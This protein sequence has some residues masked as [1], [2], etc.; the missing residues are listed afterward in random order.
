M[1]H[2]IPVG[3]SASLNVSARDFYSAETL[4]VT[5]GQVYEFICDPAQKWTDWFISS[6]ADGFTNILANIAGLRLRKVKCFTLCGCYN[7]NEQMLFRIG[8]HANLAMQLS[9]NVSF[10]A[11]DAKGFYGNNKGYLNMVV[12]RV[13]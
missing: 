10:F 4:V 1:D 6:N 9:G 11:N 5:S 12:K 8:T 7:Q 13:S 2:R 3:Q